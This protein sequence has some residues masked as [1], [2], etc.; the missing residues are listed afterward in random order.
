MKTQ[1]REIRFE[2]LRPAL[3]NKERARYALVLLPVGLL[4][5]HGPHLP[6]G[7]DPLVASKVALEAC[8][9]LGKGVV[10]PALF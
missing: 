6:V 2:M 4:E 10:M 3:F 7:N 9:R 1:I 8:R 5:N